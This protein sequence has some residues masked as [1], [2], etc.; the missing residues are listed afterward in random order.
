[1]NR[2]AILAGS[3]VVVAA[4]A[5]LVAAMVPGVLAQPEPHEPPGRIDIAEVTIAPGGVSG[6][7]ATLSVDTRLR[8]RGGPSEN[9][10]VEVRATRLETG[11]VE[12]T[13]RIDVGTLRDAQ[14]V[15][16][17][18]NVSVER[19][20]GYR[21]ETIVYQDGRRV[22]EGGKEVRGVG[23][24][25]PAYA[26]S[27]VEFHRFGRGAGGLPVIEFTIADV[28]G[29]RTTLDVST[30]LSN[31]GD[32]P[33]GG[34]RLV[35]K[36]RQSDSGIVANEAIV[37]VG[38]IEPGRTAT[39]SAS[40]TVAGGYNYY[41]D[42]VLWKDGVIVGTARAA[43]NL[44][45]RETVSVNQTTREIGL[46]VSDFERGEETGGTERE[47]EAETPTPMPAEGG[48]PGF[49]VGA[50]LAAIALLAIGLLRRRRST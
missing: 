22:E 49:G 5:V 19:A 4:A 10:T 42:A 16:V 40:L 27:S 7:T 43:A 3:A 48:Q 8:H 37:E 11:L 15:S 25:Q 44:D 9:V 39:P 31:T 45:P 21:I 12:A 50:A 18:G 23:A 26:R 1:M 13:R 41:L 33:A 34:L 17:V 14:E 28:R 35:L 32:D 2:E 20:G 6:E 46:K 24:L 36:A 30:Y 29:N 38:E 47:P